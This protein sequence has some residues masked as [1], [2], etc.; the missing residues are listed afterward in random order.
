[1]GHVRRQFRIFSEG[2]RADFLLKMG[3]IS[4]TRSKPSMAS[5]REKPKRLTMPSFHP[6]SFSE[7]APA[8]KSAHSAW[9][10]PDPAFWTSHGYVVVR[11]D[12]R[13]C[14]QSPGRLDSM[15]RGT[16]IVNFRH[17][18]LDSKVA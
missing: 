4:H 3:K 15:S 16:T 14:G 6:K 1:M 17:A 13:G 11:A 10:T 9:E 5:M 8:Q 12:E 2:Q 7:L 18:E